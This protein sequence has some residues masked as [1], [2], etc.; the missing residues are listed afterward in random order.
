MAAH[1]QGLRMGGVE[2]AAYAA[3]PAVD[4]LGQQGREVV[5]VQHAEGPVRIAGN[6]QGIAGL[7]GCAGALLCASAVRTDQGRAAQYAGVVMGQ[8]RGLDREQRSGVGGQRSVLGDGVAVSLAVHGGGAAVDQAY[9][10][11]DQA[12]SF[13]Q[14]V[15][16]AAAQAGS[17]RQ[18][19]GLR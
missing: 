8:H 11:R 13:G 12:G 1:G 15:V 2:H 5:L 18:Q 17:R 9:A 19:H 4:R 7:G 10:V 6:G 3:Q 16:A 14:P